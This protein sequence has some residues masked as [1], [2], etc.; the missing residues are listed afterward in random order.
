MASAKKDI[1]EEIKRITGGQVTLEA[2]QA[3]RKR[4]LTV[5]KIGGEGDPLGESFEVRNTGRKWCHAVW[6]FLYNQEWFLPARNLLR[7]LWDLHADHQR[8]SY[9]RRVYRAL[10]SQLLTET[11]YQL[12]NEAEA[13]RWSLLT[14]ADNILGKDR[15]KGR[16]SS[17]WLYAR[18]GMTDKER[19]ALDSLAEECRN[20]AEANG[21][22]SPSGFA[23]EVLRR[24]AQSDK[25]GR[26]VFQRLSGTEEF[27]L[28]RSYLGV[29]LDY[30]KHAP[31]NSSKGKRLEDVA[32]YLFSLLPGCVPRRN[33]YDLAG[34]SEHDL[35]VSNMS[36][37]SSLIGD[38][39]GRDFLI[40]CKNWNQAVGA[41]QVGYFLFR[42]SLT[43]CRFGVIIASQNITRT[44]EAT[45]KLTG[46]AYAHALVRRAFHEHGSACVVISLSDLKSLA[47]GQASGLTSLLMERLG[48]F[49]FG[50]DK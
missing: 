3:L 34:A 17:H 21:W 7:E 32:F 36:P 33:L 6:S 49:R 16:Y 30:M 39:F 15:E 41:E 27:H 18:F 28:T 45:G 1:G 40:E 22:D 9:K 42:M 2:A 48:D 11:A 35:V 8:C 23:E 47:L 50:T 12:G 19:K 14:Q 24:F 46:D 13:F 44:P 43:H 10:L 20:E 26:V 38:V 37:T 5:C 4:I 29:L 25:N 31:D